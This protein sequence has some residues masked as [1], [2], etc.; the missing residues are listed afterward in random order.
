MP[1]EQLGKLVQKTG[2]YPLA[3]DLYKRIDPERSLY[4]KRKESL[5][6]ILAFQ[7]VTV[8]PYESLLERFSGLSAH[9]GGPIWPHWS[10]QVAARHCRNLSPIDSRPT[11][12]E[13][14]AETIEEPVVWGGAICHH[15]GHQVADFCT[16]L[17]HAKSV[18]PN[19]KFLFA[20]KSSAQI[21]TLAQTPQFFRSLL[22]WYGIERSQIKIVSRP[23]LARQLLVAPQAE[24]LSNYGPSD[25]YLN[26]IDAHVSRKQAAGELP[27]STQRQEA[28]YVSRAGLEN[29]FAGESY[30]EALMHQ[31]G[32]KI[33][34]PETQQ[35]TEQLA[36]YMTSEQLIFS[37]GSAI[38]GLQL[39]GRFQTDV[40]VINRR[41]RERLAKNMIEPRAYSLTYLDSVQTVLHGFTATGLAN[42]WNGLAIQNEERLV[43]AL[44]TIHP[45]LK[46]RWRSAIYTEHRDRDILSW[47]KRE[48]QPEKSLHGHPVHNLSSQLRKAGLSHIKLPL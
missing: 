41:L 12:P 2:L 42:D 11:Q 45:K 33:I 18:Y 16:R 25:D 37:A 13:Q 28:V 39:L 34:R 20:A 15:F 40:Q 3:R 26:L 44:R 30:I 48:Q 6:E 7:N 19:A 4:P 24:Q 8:V 29:R 21:E 32:I 35:L 14:I 5:G 9:H 38:H 10:A 22:D 46:Q 36:A 23:I 27:V 1:L 31:V 17:I 47:I 43:S